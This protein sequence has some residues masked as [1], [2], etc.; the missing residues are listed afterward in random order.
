MTPVAESSILTGFEALFVITQAQKKLKNPLDQF[1][2]IE[3]S[4]RDVNR[5]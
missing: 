4:I 5:G 3:G 1:A 2:E